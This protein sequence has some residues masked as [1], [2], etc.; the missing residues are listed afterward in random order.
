MLD[1]F[2]SLG[3]GQPDRDVDNP[4]DDLKKALEKAKQIRPT[5]PL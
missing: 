4:V 5:D 2:L 3:E 1:Y